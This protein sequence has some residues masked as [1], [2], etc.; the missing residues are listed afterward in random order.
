MVSLVRLLLVFLLAVTVWV[1]ATGSMVRWI[2]RAV[3]KPA[4]SVPAWKRILEVTSVALGAAGL[5]AMAYAHWVEPYWPKVTRVSIISPLVKGDGLRIVHLSDLHSDPT[6]RLEEKIPQ[7]VDEL[8][9][10]LVM[11]TG[12]GANSKEGLP[13]FR[14]CMRRISENH[15]TYGVQGNWE[16]WWFA[17]VDVFEDTGV[18]ELDGAGELVMVGESPVWVAGAAVENETSMAAAMSDAPADAF[19]V[20]LH[21][22]PAMASRA[23][24]LGA[25]LVL[26][27]DTH[28]GQVRIPA[29]GALIRIHRHGVWYPA[30]LHR[31]D[32][33]HLYVS[34]GI[35]MEGGRAPRVRFMC[36]PEIV[37]ID[38]QPHP[39]S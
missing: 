31:V 25:H 15:P 4:K 37:V 1:L 6:V 14:K 23:A 28:G 24:S 36:R 32:G 39:P 3:R 30:G 21:H 33:A 9:P 38:V 13:V 34:Q 26:T 7:M 16:A 18:T 17:D 2:V 29:L 20:F 19:T 27:G 8:D 5:V 22:F 11:F 10:D 12:D 35:G